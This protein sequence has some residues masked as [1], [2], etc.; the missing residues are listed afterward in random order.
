MQ[1]A[2]NVALLHLEG[3]KRGAQSDHLLRAWLFGGVVR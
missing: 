2:K 3:A 1:R